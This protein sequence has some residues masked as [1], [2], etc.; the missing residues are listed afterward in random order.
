MVQ[1]QVVGRQGQA[2]GR[3]ERILAAARRPWAREL[4]VLAA[5]LAAGVAATWPLASYLTGRLP[6]S[7]DVAVYV[8][9]MWWVA[10]Q[11]IGLHNLDRVIT[12]IG[13][14]ELGEPGAVITALRQRHQ[15][16]A[17]NLPVAPEFFHLRRARS[18][19]GV[20]SA[21]RSA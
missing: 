17:L 7:R 9:D 19:A 14:G 21:M 4:T 20:R 18:C 6:A 2:V 8:W 1:G 12:Q 11:I 16:V 15:D 5:Y 3:P 10:H 13:P